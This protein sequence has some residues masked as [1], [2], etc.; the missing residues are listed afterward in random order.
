MPK[1]IFS[2]N[3]KIRATETPRL[4]ALHEDVYVWAHNPDAVK[5]FLDSHPVY[6]Y[7][8]QQRASIGVADAEQ[9]Q[10]HRPD[11][12]LNPEGA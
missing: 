5:S 1:Q 6:G 4:A 12:I 2:T 7:D 8:Y 3:A 11:L 9:V 10:R